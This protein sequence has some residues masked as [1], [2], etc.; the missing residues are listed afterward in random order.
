VS[1][2]FRG[3]VRRALAGPV[4]GS[5]A[6][7]FA[8]PAVTAIVADGGAGEAG[9][10][11][12]AELAEAMVRAGVPRGRM[13]VLLSGAAPPGPRE[14]ERARVLRETLGMPVIPH[15]PA[16]AAFEPGRLADGAPLALEDELREAEAV[17]VCGCFA[18]DA[19]GE[20]RGG[21]AALLPGLASAATRAAY[22]RALPAG[23]PAERAAAALAA[24]LAVLE[25]VPVDFALVWSGGDPPEVLA[26]T[27]REVF[28]AC[29]T[30]G[31]TAP[32]ATAGA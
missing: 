19:R 9:T 25:H 18:A 10:V 12:L 3:A 23:G 7:H 14:R 1:V 20:L 21:P 32:R 15:D 6:S 29:A 24:S 30:G 4:G 11:A 28:E 16:Q 26:G 5:M 22:A 31:W 27:G 13:F 2:S 17:V 8:I